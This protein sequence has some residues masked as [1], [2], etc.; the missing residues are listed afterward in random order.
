MAGTVP[1]AAPVTASNLDFEGF[2]ALLERRNDPGSES[3]GVDRD[4]ETRKGF[5]PGISVRVM[6]SSQGSTRIKG[7]GDPVRVDNGDARPGASADVLFDVASFLISILPA[8]KEC[9]WARRP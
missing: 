4:Q 9:I 5:L 6:E 3:T 1:S 2:P 8:S 7:F